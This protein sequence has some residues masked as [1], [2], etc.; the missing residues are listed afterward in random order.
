M[1]MVEL[2]QCQQTVFYTI[3]HIQQE[4]MDLQERD[5]HLKDGMKAQMEQ[6]ETGQN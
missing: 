3:L 2:V 6:E 4:Q 1:Q 5:I